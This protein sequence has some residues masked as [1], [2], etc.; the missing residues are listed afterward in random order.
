[1]TSC[2]LCGKETSS[3]TKIKLEGTKLKVC[4]DCSD[5]GEEVKTTSKRKRRKKK[6]TSSRNRNNQKV[7]NPDY[8]DILKSAREDKVMTQEALAEKLNEKKS[9]ISKMER[10]ELKPDEDTAK[11]LEKE[12]GVDLYVNPEVSNYETQDGADDREAT[13]GDVANVKD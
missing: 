8:G 6:K 13:L 3:T 5:L 7:L 4:E 9:R 2:E 10:G 12:L 11:K 1:M